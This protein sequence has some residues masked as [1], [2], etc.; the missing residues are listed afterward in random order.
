MTSG[1]VYLMSP[2]YC[3]IVVRGFLLHILPVFHF[4]VRV[5]L[6]L[7]CADLHSLFCFFSIRMFRIEEIFLKA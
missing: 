5:H 4:V 2:H 1:D 6:A 7:L 3:T